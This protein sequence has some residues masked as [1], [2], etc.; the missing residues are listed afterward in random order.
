M[1]DLKVAELRLL[2]CFEEYLQL[3]QFESRDVALQQRQVRART[4]KA[5]IRGNI[6]DLQARLQAKQ[7][8]YCIRG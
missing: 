8:R 1:S 2:V 6:T 5:E 4:E 7:V 3:L